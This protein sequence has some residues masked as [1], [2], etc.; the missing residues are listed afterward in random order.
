MKLREKTDKSAKKIDHNWSDANDGI[1][2]FRIKKSYGSD[3][4]KHVLPWLVKH[5]VPASS[6][7]LIY[8]RSQSFKT[9]FLI[10]KCCRVAAGLDYCGKPTKQGIVYLVA[11]EGGSGIA[12]R[13]RAWEL[14]NK[15]TVGNNLIVVPHTV[16]PTSDHQRQALIDDIKAECER[17]NKYIALVV[18]DTMS[19]CANG[20][21]END[22]G[23]VS[24]YLNQCRSIATQVNCTVINVHHTK[25]DSDDFR[26]SS[27]IEGN[28]DFMIAVKRNMNSQDNQTTV[29]L[30]KMKE[31]STK[32]R[33]ELALNEVEI[34]AL[35]EDGAPVETL[36]VSTTKLVKLN[37]ETNGSPKRATTQCETD[38]NWILEMLKQQGG[39]LS[40]QQL[41][42][43][44]LAE[45]GKVKNAAVRIGRAR[46][47]LLE[48]ELIT[49]EKT[50]SGV[51]IHLV[52]QE[53][54]AA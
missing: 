25:K 24:K 48:H 36:C 51:V 6:V 19:Q 42:L 26:G 53:P 44:I 8:G 21:S 54:L 18:F 35:D 1:E 40:L 11:A 39:T 52:A 43:L 4:Y 37:N 38:A 31:G 27:T 23:E 2:Q 14:E 32:Y 17:Q 50:D 33:W 49:S 28:L 46:D 30:H 22:A 5:M 41:N 29:R 16:F 12:K 9:F 7:G 3:G 34:D 13:I 45:I 47:K 20:A 15:T 10:D